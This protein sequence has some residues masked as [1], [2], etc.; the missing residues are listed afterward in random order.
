MHM[1]VIPAGTS[2]VLPVDYQEVIWLT[3]SGGYV[4][5]AFFKTSAHTVVHQR[6]ELDPL[7]LKT[8]AL[9]LS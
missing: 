2:I 3:S 6:L 5:L 8:S 4:N 9:P 1:L 7:A